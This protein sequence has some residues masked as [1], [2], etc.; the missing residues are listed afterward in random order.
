MRWPNDERPNRRQLNWEHW[1]FV[2]N[3]HGPDPIMRVENSISNR[4]GGI[5]WR[6]ERVTSIS[7]TFAGGDVFVGVVQVYAHVAHCLV[8]VEESLSGV[9]LEF[10]L[11]LL[12][13]ISIVLGHVGVLGACNHSAYLLVADAS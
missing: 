10:L 13:E 8:Q 1:F 9:T 5:L 7:D 3:I 11:H 12:E 2:L 6:K 4:S